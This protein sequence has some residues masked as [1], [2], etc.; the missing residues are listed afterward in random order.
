MP[1]V[2]RA[3]V[4][5]PAGPRAA[6][7][8]LALFALAL[9]L[10]AGFVLEQV[11]TPWEDQR[12]FISDSA[13]YDQRA[14]E[15]AAGDVLG[16]TP[17]FLS[18][19]YCF[20]LG[21]VYA[22]AGPSVLAAELAQAL[23]GALAVLLLHGATQRLFS[24]GAAHVAAL[25]LALHGPSLY[26]TSLL[27]PTTLVLFLH[28]ALLRVLAGGAPT[29]RR[30]LAA[31]VL[32][33]LAVGAKANALLLLPA[34]GGWIL[35]G[36]RERPLR[37]RLL[38]VG[39]LVAGAAVAVSPI[40]WRNV[41]SSGHFVLVTTTGGRNLAKG[42]GPTANGTHSMLAGENV[43]IKHYLEGTVDVERAVQEDEQLARETWRYMLADPGR[44]LALFGRKLVLFF[45]DMELGIRDNYPF[46][47]TQSRILALPLVPFAL[48]SSLGLAGV[49]LRGLAD[50]R[51]ALVLVL[52]GTQVA[53]FVLVFV[54]GRY[55]VVAV[56][57]L[58][59]FAGAAASAFAS[60]LRARRFLRP[61]GLAAA[62]LLAL[63][64]AR[65]SVEGFEAPNPR[66]DQLEFSGEWNAARGRHM[67]AFEDFKAAAG[68]PRLLDSAFQRAVL[69]ARA[70]DCLDHAG[71]PARARALRLEVLAYAERELP[72]RA[73]PLI[74][75]L[76]S[77][78]AAPPEPAPDEP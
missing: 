55:R 47:R 41:A 16:D 13:Y 19:L 35:L 8:P 76:R 31:G 37:A 18:P 33:G 50:R 46:A 63:A 70:A 29:P 20:A 30:A 71:E 60:D 52:L 34:V 14:R 4:R 59:A 23:L 77:R 26:W 12:E 53:S 66:G 73:A 67:E 32:V 54:L 69:L 62:A 17:G 64:L 40:T 28:A 44:T 57:L 65:V 3:P 9:A 45:N 22:V 24:R 25:L 75:R 27:L 74:E 1:D 68:E 78:L 21:A 38:A 48:V 7:L 6:L 61:A 36:W 51:A 11:G 58:A 2:D 10:R 15:I 5:R 56:A 49:L 72:P 43:N 42:N 39:L